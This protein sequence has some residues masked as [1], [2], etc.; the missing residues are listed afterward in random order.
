M[1]I[2]ASLY[3]VPYRM[4]IIIDYESDEDFCAEFRAW[5][6]RADRSALSRILPG[7]DEFLILLFK[8]SKSAGSS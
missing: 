1:K 6:A 5:P 2:L 4:L 7:A 3:G 8:N